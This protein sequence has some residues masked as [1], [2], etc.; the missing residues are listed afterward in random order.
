MKI[1]DTILF[2]LDGTLTD[3]KIGITRSV[4][5]ALAKFDIYESDLDKL[6]PFIGPPLYE[7]F[8]EFYGFSEAKA[9]QA[10]AYYREYF[11]QTGMYENAV[12]PG[13]PA[14]LADLAHK[15][16]RLIVATSKPTVFSVE[17]LKHFG[18]YEYFTLVVGSNLDGTRIAKTEIIEH[19]LCEIACEQ[20]ASLV[21]VGDRKHDLIGAQNTGVDSI[22]VT[23]GYGALEELQNANPTYLVNS[24]AELAAILNR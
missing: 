15:G 5:Y 19:I 2:D 23:Y 9:H 16:K 13:I 21:M 20:R 6:I 17:I 10:V 8:M 3:P 1:Y 18:I 11:S 24:V 12:F 22:A 4:Q 14:L 7:S